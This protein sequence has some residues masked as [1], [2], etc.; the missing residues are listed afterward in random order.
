L[1]G[2]SLVAPPAAGAAPRQGLA[3]G[4]FQAVSIAGGDAGYCALLSD[5]KVA[6]WGDSVDDEAGVPPLSNAAEPVPHLVPGVGGVEGLYSYGAGFCV[7][8]KTGKA[9]CWGD[10]ADGALGDG[11]N[12]SAQLPHTV[13]GL[14]GVKTIVANVGPTICAVLEN[15][16]VKC[17]GDNQFG[18]VGDG[19]TAAF[20]STPA[21]V[22]DLSGVKTVAGVNATF[23]ALLDNGGAECWGD[24]S[25][26]SLGDS[27]VLE[28]ASTPVPVTGLSG[29]VWLLSSRLGYCAILG[30]RDVECWGNDQYGSLGDGS[31]A[32]SAT[33]V[34][35]SGLSDVVDL[36]ATYFNYC[37]AL[38]GGGVRCW[39]LGESG[40]LG[41]GSTA[42]TQSSVPVPAKSLSNVASLYGGGMGTCAVLHTGSTKCWGDNSF[43][44]AGIGSSA[45]PVYAPTSVKGLTNAVSL[46]SA[47]ASWCA[48]LRGGGVK[49]WG[50]NSAGAL[51]QNEDNVS[52]S[53]A[54]LPVPG[55]V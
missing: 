4:R 55:F 24:Q 11:S 39:G 13:A 46:A 47:G 38:G 31:A 50:D 54:P 32:E 19:S 51:G 17:W 49:C 37:A 6:C 34:K 10:N 15:S 7:V 28:D 44:E 27:S 22:R 12:A 53:Y 33:P 21:T 26:D 9:Q 48:V 16:T 5:A 52:T 41:T 30:N 14:S 2:L 42:A 35:V 29:A 45:T 25:G 43:G 20:V 36:S 1:V 23:C 40:Y 3:A 18:L 8:L